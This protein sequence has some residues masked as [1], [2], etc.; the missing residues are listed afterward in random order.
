MEDVLQLKTITRLARC[1][2]T[3]FLKN[4]SRSYFITQQ[5]QPFLYFSIA[6][7]LSQESM[8]GKG[9]NPWDNP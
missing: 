6:Y 7:M 3:L 5:M 4:A 8:R 1:Q 2:M 9:D